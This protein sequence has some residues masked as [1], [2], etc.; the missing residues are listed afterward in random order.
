MRPRFS[1]PAL[2]ITIALSGCG[3]PSAPLSSADQARK[4][5]EA[6]LEAWKAG[7]P[8]SSLTGDKPAID[9]VDFQWKAGKKLAA[10]SIASDQA[11]AEA[12]TFKVGLTLADAKEPK[13]VE[14]KAIG[15]DPIH[16]LRD[17]DY[18][19]TLNMDNAPAAAKAPG[20][21]R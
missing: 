15:V 4:S 1:L 3:S 19:R 16:I 21:R 12:H 14:Y 2:M 9:F 10:Y 17:E 20:K 6:G 7:R 5:L 18:N 11:D 13:Q 8:A